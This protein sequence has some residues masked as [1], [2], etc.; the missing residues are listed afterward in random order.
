M[1]RLPLV[2]APGAT[3]ALDIAWDPA[4]SAPDTAAFATLSIASNAAASPASPP[5]C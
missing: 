3:Q 4:A 2:L 1:S 5:A